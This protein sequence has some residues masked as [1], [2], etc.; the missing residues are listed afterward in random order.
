MT[1]L[2]DALLLVLT[3][4]LILIAIGIAL[5]LIS[6]RRQRLW[7]MLEQRWTS[8]LLTV[9]SGDAPAESMHA[10]VEPAYRMHF[11][12]FLARYVR[13][14]SGDERLVLQR[15]AQ[16]YLG[17]LAERTGTGS[18]ER[19]AFA[20]QTLSTLGL[21][22]YSD[23]IVAA[24]DHPSLLVAMVAMQELARSEHPEYAA[25]ILKRLHRFDQW[26]GRYLG[27]LLAGMG[28]RVSPVLRLKLANPEEAPRVRAVVATALHTLKDAA[29]ADLAASIALVE[30]DRDL[31]IA[32]LNILGD[33]GHAQHLEVIRGLTHTADFV[34]RA[35]AIEAL[36]KLGES[37]DTERIYQALEDENPWVALRASA[38]LRRAGANDLLR[39]FAT[40]GSPRA[41]VAREALAPGA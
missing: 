35:Q 27:S 20:I 28:M 22:D 26:S 2:T 3:S 25:A 19:R 16:P 39:K 9:L 6:V 8:P 33:L 21:D 12:N 18:P 30:S 15:L 10:L 14:F 34:I 41:D 37:Q 11:V 32:V 31:L 4:C 13:R 7:E 24:L 40:S 23:V 29:S 17:Q 1:S 36:G 38:A 5:R